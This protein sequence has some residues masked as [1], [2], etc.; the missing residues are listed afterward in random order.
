MFNIDKTH[1]FKILN[2]K[3]EI[4]NLQEN[5]VNGKIKTELENIN[6]GNNEI[7]RKW[8]SVEPLTG[9]H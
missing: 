2:K 7:V 8:I 3:T 9:L 4:F 6:K 1:M 5:C